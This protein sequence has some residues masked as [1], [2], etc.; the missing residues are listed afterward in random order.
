MTR[1]R[2]IISTIVG[3]VILSIAAWGLPQIW[4]NTEFLNLQ[5]EKR[6]IEIN[7]AIGELVQVCNF[8]VSRGISVDYCDRKLIES[9]DLSCKVYR[10]RLDSCVGVETFLQERGKL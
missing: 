3:I 10:D 1:K 6:L 8:N 2:L 4:L 7:D 9:W 5:S